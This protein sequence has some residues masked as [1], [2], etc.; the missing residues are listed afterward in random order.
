MDYTFRIFNNFDEKN[1]KG[2]KDLISKK[3]PEDELL[4]RDILS[5]IN[6][7]LTN[8]SRQN[9]WW[10]ST[11]KDIK[12]AIEEYFFQRDNK[13]DL[14][15]ISN[16]SG[17]SLAIIKNHDQTKYLLS[18]SITQ[19]DITERN[20]F[21]RHAGTIHNLPN[22]LIEKMVLD[23]SNRKESKANG[24]AGMILK[25]D[26]TPCAN[27]VLPL[28]YAGKSAEIIVYKKI[29]FEDIVCVI[30]P[31][32]IIEFYEKIKEKSKEEIREEYVKRLILNNK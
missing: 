15:N 5:T 23:V 14:I 7:H 29:L 31:N 13:D 19:R 32:E 27:N 1:Y 3:I 2:G 6:S 30:T 26:Y 25:K 18:D 16:N 8:G 10:I 9:S 20:F 28:S 24:K 17:N 12:I 21:I 4:I 11:T 22:S